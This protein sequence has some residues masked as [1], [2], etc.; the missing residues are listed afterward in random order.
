MWRKVFLI[1]CNPKIVWIRCAL[2]LRSCRHLSAGFDTPRLARFPFI[3]KSFS[4]INPGSG[5]TVS[6]ENEKPA[7]LL[8]PS[9]LQK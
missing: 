9:L 3:Q 7:F 1:I 8:Y 6:F 5:E 4:P 2:S